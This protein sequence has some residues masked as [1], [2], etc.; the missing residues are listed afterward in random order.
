M[1][2]ASDTRYLILQRGSARLQ[3][4]EIRPGQRVTI[5][6]TPGNTLVV[7]DRKC[8]RVHCEVFCGNGTWYVRD[9]QSRNGVFVEGAKIDGDTVVQI[10]QM[11]SVGDFTI[12]MTAFHPEQTPVDGLGNS[13]ATSTD[14]QDGFAIIERKSMTPYNTPEGVQ[15]TRVNPLGAADLFKLSQAMQVADDIGI[16]LG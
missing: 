5:G 16:E 8:S 6:R 9:N 13:H 3:V 11:I 14:E 1:T 2:A 7:P 4:V 12:Q 15:H 10:G